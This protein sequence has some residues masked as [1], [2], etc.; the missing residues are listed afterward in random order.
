MG[1]T[2][3]T[4]N[5]TAVTPT[6]E[7]TLEELRASAI[8]AQAPTQEVPVVVPNAPETAPVSPGTT[9][10]SE[11][12]Y[13]ITE[14]PEGVV[15][16]MQVGNT[17]QIF[18]AKDYKTALEIV[19]KSNADTHK[20]AHGLNG[21]LQELKKQIPATAP[22]V[23]ATP[24]TP[25]APTVDPAEKA[26][27]DYLAEQ[28][29]KAYGFQNAEQMKSVLQAS[30]TTNEHM[31]LSAIE[32]AF[33]QACPDFPDSPEAV[34]AIE[35]T[36][37]KYALPMNAGGLIAAHALAVREK[38][39]VPAT[40]TAAVT[41]RPVPNPTLITGTTPA[42]STVDEAALRTMPLDQLRTLALQK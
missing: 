23:P 33:L 26:L 2:T 28:T 40:P 36:I 24:T 15:V 22:A 25:A 38:L 20:W 10:S 35:T 19:T 16:T 42:P 1:T 41:A 9:A 27:Q 4:P 32:S 7:P 6:P 37:E 13:S 30:R 31:Q 12:P 17:P 29:A 5:L 14:G 39:Y 8:A 11:V 21:Q 34:K 18:K 3:T